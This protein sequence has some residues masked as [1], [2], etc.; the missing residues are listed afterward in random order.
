VHELSAGNFK[1]IFTYDVQSENKD[2]LGMA[3]VMPKAQV[4]GTATTPN[5]NTDIQNT[6]IIKANLKNNEPVVYRFYAGWEK[7]DSRFT[8]VEGFEAFLKKD[9]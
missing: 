5:V 8:S 6:Y 4:A 3:I 1:G 7:S 2:K 9:I